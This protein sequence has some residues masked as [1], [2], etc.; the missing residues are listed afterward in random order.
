MDFANIEAF[1]A[2]VE[3]GGFT[4][5]AHALHLS[6]PALSR[7]IGLLEAAL[8]KP[9]F[10]RGRRGA[11]LT[12]AG[13]VFLPY[14]HT[15]LA[16]LRDGFTAVREVEEGEVGT[17]GVAIV[18]TLASTGVAARLGHF[19]EAHPR[20][21]VLL[22]T[23]S[24]AEVSSLVRRGE[25]A[26][27]LRYFADPDPLVVSRRLYRE[28]M[29]VV[30][31]PGHR[32]ATSRSLAAAKLRGETWIAFPSKRR[33][34]VDPFGQVLVRALATAG[35]DGAEIIAIDSLTAQ[36]RLVEAGFGLALVP[37]S[38]V[39]EELQRGT[40]KLLKVAGLAASVEVTL[41]HRKGAFLSRAAQRLMDALGAI[42][43]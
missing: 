4:R 26:I 25:V 10:E 30:A 8:R 40:L 3:R 42:G 22:R 35:L 19:R 1:V 20:V 31:A 9:L 2:V 41:L 38:S 28:A 27:G 17:V 32:L 37:A 7:R 43:P 36:K 29:V 24:S 14:A 13:R 16:N 34:S 18:G 15:A 11:P 12:D 23:G 21:R 5:A 39:Q 6:Q 33:S